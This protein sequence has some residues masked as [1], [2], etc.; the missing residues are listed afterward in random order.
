MTRSGRPREASPPTEKLTSGAL[1]PRTP[2]RMPQY[3]GAQPYAP[4]VNIGSPSMYACAA[5]TSLLDICHRR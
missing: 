2:S 4:S 5:R 1:R 3:A